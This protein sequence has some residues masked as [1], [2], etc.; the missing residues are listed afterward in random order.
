MGFSTLWVVKTAIVLGAFI[1]ASSLAANGK[2]HLQNA[3][4]GTLF[5]H[6]LPTA[7]GG[8]AG[9]VLGRI[10]LAPGSARVL[11]PTFHPGEE[12]M[13]ALEP[14][15]IAEFS[16]QEAPAPGRA[17]H[18]RVLFG[19]GDQRCLLTYRVLEQAGVLAGSLEPCLEFGPP[20]ELIRTSGPGT[21]VHTLVGIQEK[22]GSGNTESK[23]PVEP[24]ATLANIDPALFPE[25]FGG[26]L[27][28]PRKSLPGVT[29]VLTRTRRLAVRT[30]AEPSAPAA[31]PAAVPK[32]P[33][34][35]AKAAQVLEGH[36]P[37]IL[38]NQSGQEL[39]LTG[40][41]LG[42]TLAG[43]EL[44]TQSLDEAELKELADWS[45]LTP[46]AGHDY[47]LRLLPGQTVLLG[48]AAPPALAAHSTCLVLRLAG[49]ERI[50]CLRYKVRAGAGPILGPLRSQDQELL[51]EAGE[52]G[53]TLVITGFTTPRHAGS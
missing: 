49:D 19:N 37:V 53:D 2:V 16:W 46:P 26:P 18:L 11:K 41:R 48:L 39:F 24:L 21:V 23:V 38:S 35:V 44:V 47:G 28:K 31:E 22:K 51:G 42:E 3:T 45:P 1:H 30:L 8:H 50:C 52:A 33:G 40:T 10:L 6:R 20:A 7:V 43:P 25:E 27:F 13:L 4:G 12:A 14:G 5:L 34:R 29:G 32:A 17:V 36:A 15:E 9:T